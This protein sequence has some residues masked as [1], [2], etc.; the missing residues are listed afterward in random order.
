MDLYIFRHGQTYFS[1][2][3]LPYEDKVK[4]ASILPEGI[5]AVNK[6]AKD[7]KSVETD[8]DFTSPFKRC[9]QTTKIVSEVTGKKFIKDENLRDWDPQTEKVQAMI[10]RILIFCK[11]LKTENYKAVSICTH[12]YPINAL[13]AYFTKGSIEEPD[14]HNFPKCGILVSIIDGKVSYRDF[15]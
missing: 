4:S 8:A 1:K 9:L 11:E 6:I 7:L 5:I 3:Q 12:G 2:N 10:E 15:N 14:L 13:I